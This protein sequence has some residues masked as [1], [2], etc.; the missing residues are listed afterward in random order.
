MASSFSFDFSTS[1]RP[2]DAQAQ[3]RGR[4]TERLSSMG[5]RLSKQTPTSASY[6]PKWKPIIIGTL[7]WL[8]RELSGQKVNVTF[9]SDE[10]ETHMKVSGKVSGKAQPVAD[11]E[12]WTGVLSTTGY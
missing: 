6:R 1:E 11:K 2:D 9:T 5:M 7:I 12:F 8:S 3:L 4:L 10:G